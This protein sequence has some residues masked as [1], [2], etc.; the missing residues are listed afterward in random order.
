MRFITLVSILA[1]NNSEFSNNTLV[2][3]I[4]NA[5][6]NLRGAIDAARSICRLTRKLLNYFYLNLPY[7]FSLKLNKSKVGL[8]G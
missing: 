6:A 1:L 3:G 7:L 4:I 2:I 5:A 8:S